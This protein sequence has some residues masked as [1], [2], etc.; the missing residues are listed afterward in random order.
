MM[1]MLSLLVIAALLTGCKQ[2]SKNEGEFKK[3]TEKKQDIQLIVEYEPVS[4]EDSKEGKLVKYGESLI[5]ETYNYFYKDDKKIGNHLACTN[6]H[7]NGGTKPYGIPYIGMS[8]VFPTYIGREDRA[9]TL[10]ER[11]NGCFE[12]SMNGEAIPEDSKEMKAMIAYMDHLSKDVEEE[13]RIEGQGLPD[14]DAP[15]RKTD[16]AQGEEVYNMQCAVCHGQNGRG[17]K[18]E[19]EDYY[20]YP[21]LWGDD[22]YNDGAGM[23]RVLTAARFIKANMPLGTTYDDPQLTDEEAYDVAAYI[24]SFDRPVKEGKEKDYPDLSKKPKDSPYGPYDDDIPQEQHK[25]GPFNF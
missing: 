9:V 24:N 3:T 1:K 2:A 13:G 20:T 23:S 17:L 5:K 8:S 21:P 15:E 6:C 22:S 12:R 7:L 16:L 4:F 11:I 25:Y 19:G 14:F 18:P 10:E